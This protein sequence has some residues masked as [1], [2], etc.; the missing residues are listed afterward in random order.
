MESEITYSFTL[1]CCCRRHGA[2]ARALQQGFV[3]QP[4]EWLR[5]ECGRPVSREARGEPVG[6]PHGDPRIGISGHQVGRLSEPAAERAVGGGLVCVK[7]HPRAH[8]SRRIPSHQ[9]RVS[10]TSLNLSPTTLPNTFPH[11]LVPQVTLP[12]SRS[13]EIIINTTI[14]R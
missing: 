9:R 1:C 8:A 12:H 3:E 2:T 7:R 11:V 13:T 10:L 4:P 14:K 5:L 6:R